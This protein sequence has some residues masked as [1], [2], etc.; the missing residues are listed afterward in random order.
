MRGFIIRGGYN[1]TLH[2]CGLTPPAGYSRRTTAYY[3]SMTGHYLRR[4]AAD[5]AGRMAAALSTNQTMTVVWLMPQAAPLWILAVQGQK[6][7]DN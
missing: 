1:N 4:G 6:P 2:R 5:G 7:S 3:L